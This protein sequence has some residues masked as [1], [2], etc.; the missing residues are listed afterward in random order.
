MNEE[1]VPFD[2]SVLPNN[3]FLI[4]PADL[5][6]LLDDD[7]LVL[8]DAN[9][10]DVYSKGHI[11]GAI[12]VGFHAFSDTTGQPG[13]YGWGTIK[14]KDELQKV[15]EALGINNEK[16]V[17]IYSDVFAGP[18]ADG[19]AV[20]QSKA[21]GLNNFKLLVG[22]LTHWR[23][24]GYPI[25]TEESPAAQPVTGLV[26]SDFDESYLATKE[27]VYENLGKKLLLDTRTEREF[28]GSQNAGEPR[29]GHIT[30]AEHLLWT[31]LLNENGTPKPAQEIIDVLA[32]FGVSP[33]DE[34]TVY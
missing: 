1:V 8:L 34:F 14:S 3:D 2:V 20:W 30:G 5:L 33:A 27:Y 17:V 24:L 22:G 31:S 25:T 26:L 28:K 32:D 10:P 19:R 15:M 4:G 12:H 23:E 9:N 29:G 6:E 11:P 16:T 13:D 21:A 18:G 7:N